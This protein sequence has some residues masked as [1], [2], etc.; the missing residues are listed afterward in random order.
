MPRFSPLC[1]IELVC[2]LSPCYSSSRLAIVTRISCLIGLLTSAG[3]LFLFATVERDS[4]QIQGNPILF[5]FLSCREHR[6]PEGL[7]SALRQS[8]EHGGNEAGE[9]PIDRKAFCPY[10]TKLP[11]HRKQPQR[12]TISE[13]MPG[14][15]VSTGKERVNGREG[16]RDTHI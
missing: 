8:L 3:L 2:L 11:S 15:G 7:R 6:P 12:R 9:D 13:H 16:K 10:F 14:P 1:Q 4:L 5:C